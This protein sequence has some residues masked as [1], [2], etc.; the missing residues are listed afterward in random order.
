MLL[1]SLKSRVVS[2][3]KLDVIGVFQKLFSKIFLLG[4]CY[5][6]KT[7]KNREKIEN[8]YKRTHFY[9]TNYIFFITIKKILK[10]RD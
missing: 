2:V 7:D 5:M 1:G 6:R 8:F 4:K 9:K 10:S 3:R